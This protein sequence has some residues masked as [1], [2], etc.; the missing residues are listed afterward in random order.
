MAALID[1]ASPPGGGHWPFLDLLRFG[2]ALLV[3]FGHVRGLLFVS[4]Q[5]V[6]APGLGTNLHLTVP[7]PTPM[8]ELRVARVAG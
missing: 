3:L 4:I 5:D 7:L 8:T 6:P 1:E 2:A